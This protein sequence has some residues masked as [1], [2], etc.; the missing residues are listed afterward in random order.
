LI[1][2]RSK[3]GREGG[4]GERRPAGRKSKCSSPSIARKKNGREKEEKELGG[5]KPAN[6]FIKRNLVP[7][8]KPTSTKVWE[9]ESNI[10]EG[11]NQVEGQGGIVEAGRKKFAAGLSQGRRTK[12]AEKKKLGHKWANSW[13]EPLRTPYK[14]ARL[15][16]H[17]EHP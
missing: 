16:I 11:R 12:S 15:P 13:E 3:E 7:R 17:V 6:P 2:E 9:R 4:R 1:G 8:Q 14:I 5:R 10:S